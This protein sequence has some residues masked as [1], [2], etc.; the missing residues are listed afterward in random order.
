MTMKGCRPGPKGEELRAARA[1]GLGVILRRLGAAVA[2]AATAA[3]GGQA[4]S[5]PVTAERTATVRL[6]RLE[7]RQAVDMARLPA[8]LQPNRRAVLAAEVGGVVERLT[9]EEGTRVREG[10][11]LVSIDTRALQQALAEAEAVFRRAQADFERAE[12]LAERRSITR[13]QLIDARAAF[14]VAAAR[15]ENARLQLS[16]SQVKAPWDGTVAV[17]RVEVGDFAVPG[18]PLL[19]LVDTTRLRV[20]AFAPAA[21]VPYLKEG[22]VAQVILEGIEGEEVAKGRVARLGVELDPNARTL[23]L[24]VELANPGGSWRPGMLARIELPRR[25]LA[26]AVLVPLSALVDFEREKILYVVE[27]GRARR[28]VVELGPVIGDEVV[29]TRGASPGEVVIVEGQQQVS[30]GQPVV[31]AT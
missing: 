15:L 2:A 30:D 11:T 7:A 14:D 12:Q 18:Q 16:K 4:P 26:N 6:L 13:Q 25:T 5:A 19:E 24:E 10:E 29:I 31:E 21:D 27:G 17:K 22:A 20:R 1:K 28:R 8:D 9:V 23:S 3:C